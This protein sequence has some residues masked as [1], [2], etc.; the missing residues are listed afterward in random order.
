MHRKSFKTWEH[1]FELSAEGVTLRLNNK[2]FQLMELF[3]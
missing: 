2:E 3:K 1:H